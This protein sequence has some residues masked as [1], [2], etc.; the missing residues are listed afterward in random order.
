MGAELA[1]STLT[2]PSP[3]RLDIGGGN[4]KRGEEFTSVDLEGGDIN[5][6][7][8]DIP[9][10]DNSVEEIW[11]SHTLEH[12]PMAKVPETLKEWLRIL[13]PGARAII[14]VPN[15]DYVARYW[16]T[17]P[18]R[19]WAEMMVFGTQTSE[20]QFHRAAFTPTLLRGDL[21]GVGFK[22][23]RV[24]FRWS[25]NQETLQAVV[26]KPI[27]APVSAPPPPVMLAPPLQRAKRKKRV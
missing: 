5:A 27:P 1:E 23:E 22:V 15:F 7:M 11:S 19:A 3:L 18:D 8:W 24:E 25:H 26:T 17:G 13:K 4:Q 9:V 12:A 10:P 6:P 20:G 21:E 14:Q 2:L 16:L